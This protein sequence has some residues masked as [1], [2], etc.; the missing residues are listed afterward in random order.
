MAEEEMPEWK[1]QAMQREAE[2]R[3]DYKRICAD[4]WDEMTEKD[5][6]QEGQENA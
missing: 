5:K 4:V 6:K 3:E 2:E 1:R